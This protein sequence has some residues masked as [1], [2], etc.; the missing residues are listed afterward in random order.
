MTSYALFITAMIGMMLVMWKLSPHQSLSRYV[1]LKGTF[2]M[3][4]FCTCSRAAVQ[5]CNSCF[6]GELIVGEKEK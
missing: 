4:Q 1:S 3:P 5:V 2:K 6:R